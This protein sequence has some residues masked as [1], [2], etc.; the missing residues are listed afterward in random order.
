MKRWLFNLGAAVS[1]ALCLAVC[2]LWVRS[3]RSPISSGVPGLFLPN[4]PRYGLWLSQGTA[5]L[6]I[7]S[8]K[9]LESAGPARPVETIFINFAGLRCERIILW[10]YGR[11]VGSTTHMFAK[12][13]S[14]FIL[15]L[16]LPSAWLGHLMWKRNRP[17]GP[18]ICR[19]CAYDLRATPDRCPECGTPATQAKPQPA[20]GAA[21]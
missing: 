18:F 16:L 13:R 7:N 11:W 9:T 5:V 6:E 3:Y 20:E 14:F 4:P 12:L 19:V 2:M 21:A 10:R 1:L 17:R 8:G 15:S